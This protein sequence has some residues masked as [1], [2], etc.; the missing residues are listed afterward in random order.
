MA[1]NCHLWTTS[2]AASWLWPVYFM[3]LLLAETEP[4]WL[5]F[6]GEKSSLFSFKTRTVFLAIVTSYQNIFPSRHFLVFL[7]GFGLT[8]CWYGRGTSPVIAC[9]ILIPSCYPDHKNAGIMGIFSLSFFLEV[10]TQLSFF[11]EWAM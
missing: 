1:Q 5:T 9:H 3:Q 7:A 4:G 10:H 6:R 8:G 2:F 11:R